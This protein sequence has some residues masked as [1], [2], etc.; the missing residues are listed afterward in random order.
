[1]LICL[2]GCCIASSLCP[3][4]QEVPTQHGGGGCPTL[5]SPRAPTLTWTTCSPTTLFPGD[6]GGALAHP[7]PDPV[8]WVLGLNL[9]GKQSNMS[10]WRTG[11]APPLLGCA[12]WPSFPTDLLTQLRSDP[13]SVPHCM[14]KF[15]L[16]LQE[17][18][19]EVWPVFPAQQE[20]EDAPFGCGVVLLH[21]GGNVAA[22]GKDRKFVRLQ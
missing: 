11:P 15:H 4:A 19:V 20:L 5:R 8:M 7:T 14:E 10:T 18:L 6:L 16:Q 2:K 1:M 22:M 3:P 9:K 13:G 12:P 21:V 17:L